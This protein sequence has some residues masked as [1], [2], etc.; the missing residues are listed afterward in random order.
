MSTKY[1]QDFSPEG[2][3]EAVPPSEAVF[4]ARTDQRWVQSVNAL[5]EREEWDELW[6]LAQKAPPIWTIRILKFLNKQSWK[7]DADSLRATG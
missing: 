5:V 4:D 7:P 2:S 3:C 1:G 6:R